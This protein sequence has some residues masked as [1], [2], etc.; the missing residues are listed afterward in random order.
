MAEP[1]N[2]V[3]VTLEE[4]MVRTLAM[5]R[6]AIKLL[7]EKG[8]IT[9]G[10]FAEDFRRKSDLPEA[11]EFCGALMGILFCARLDRCVV[12]FNLRLNLVFPLDERTSPSA[13]NHTFLYLYP[14]DR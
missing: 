14:R 8:I 9:T 10:I 5:T 4:L 12:Q 2:R 13:V 7:I 11:V 6:R 1:E 3:K